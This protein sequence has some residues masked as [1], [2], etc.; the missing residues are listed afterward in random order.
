MEID[1]KPVQPSLLQ[2]VMSDDTEEDKVSFVSNLSPTLWE[3]G[4][5][6]RDALG[7]ISSYSSQNVENRIRQD[8]ER[9]ETM[10]TL[11]RQ[12]E[13]RPSRLR[14]TE[15]DHVVLQQPI[16]RFPEIDSLP[17]Q[18]AP[19]S[20]SANSP[21]PDSTVGSPSPFDWRKM[22]A[23]WSPVRSVLVGLGLIGILA[24]V[25]AIVF[26]IQQRPP[27]TPINTCEGLGDE[28]I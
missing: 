16:L 24:V 5:R 17:P 19:S 15:I 4:E 7:R 26:I 10:P 8:Q 12:Q 11:S 25:L 21:T 3:T 14:N 6:K 1:R 23:K 9:L 18:S 22:F 27:T 28:R 2:Y 13:K 20:D